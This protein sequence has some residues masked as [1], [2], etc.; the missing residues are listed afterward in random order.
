MSTQILTV[1]PGL[2]VVIPQ[3]LNSNILALPGVAGAGGSI[4]VEYSADGVNYTSAPE[5]SSTTPYSFCPNTYNVGYQGKV[6][7]TATTAVG[8]VVVSDIS[9]PK[10]VPGVDQQSLL[11]MGIAFVTPNATTEQRLISLRMPSGSLKPNFR[12][13]IEL[14][15]TAT[16]NANVKTLRGYAGNSGAGTVGPVIVATSSAGLQLRMTMS[17]RND[18]SSIVCGSIGAAGGW[19]I[20]TT[21]PVVISSNANYL[22]TEQEFYVTGQKAT[23][24]DALTVD[25]ASIRLIQ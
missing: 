1:N 24:T 7:V 15:L 6:K 5:G 23:G 3:A 8:A 22:T 13:E 18:G 11:A 19:G 20:S 14:A 21:A 4:L 17:G 25:Q 2:P 12:L 16:N 9:Q 10:G